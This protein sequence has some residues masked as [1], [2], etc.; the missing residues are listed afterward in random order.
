MLIIDPQDRILL[1]HTETMP[2]DPELDIPRYWYVPGGGL[3]A[4][5][6]FEDALRR[7]LWE[8]VGIREAEFGPCVWVREQVLVFPET[9]EA[10]AHERF[11][12]VRVHD[13]AL[14]FENMV[15]VEGDALAAHH[16][17]TLDELRALTEV[18][19]PQD[20]AEHLPPILAGDYP[21]EPIT[22]R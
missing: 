13:N 5:E 20:I 19:F 12:P 17:W 9:G 10:L 6:S 7:E 16:W 15:G 21:P 22:I 14:N 18:I 1:F 3:E 8:E 2:L 4:G 11:F